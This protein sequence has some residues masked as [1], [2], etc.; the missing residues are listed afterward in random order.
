MAKAYIAPKYPRV[1]VSNDR[2]AKLQKA[3]DKANLTLTE[4]C[5]GIFAG[6]S[7]K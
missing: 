1:L 3:A 7:K 5:E 2:H 6:Y 4:Y